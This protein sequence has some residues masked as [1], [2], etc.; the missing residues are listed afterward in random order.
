MWLLAT[1]FLRIKG[2]N[3]FTKLGKIFCAAALLA[4][5]PLSVSHAD[6]GF[7]V[8]GS[9]GTAA[10]EIDVPEVPDFDEDDFAWK[11]FGGY[12]FGLLPIVDLGIEGGYV[13]FGAPS[14]DV[15]DTNVGLAASVGADATAFDVFGVVGVGLGPIDV[16]GKVG[17][18]YWDAGL[19]A[20]LTDLDD[21]SNN[22][23]ESV[24]DD[25]S[26]F[27]YGIGASL[28]LGSLEVRGEYELFDIDP[29]DIDGVDVS[30]WSVG[31]VFH[32]N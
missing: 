19:T 27:A 3:M 9:V 5:A 17:L 31:L 11:V 18:V 15:S 1:H 16:F 14:Q 29:A 13:D 8:G 20:S 2:I 23:S 32:F 6:S 24:S 22:V 28:S 10:I 4:L 7:Y 21:P 26:D 12:K 25:G 30:M